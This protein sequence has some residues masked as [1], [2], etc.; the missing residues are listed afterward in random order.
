MTA[1]TAESPRWLNEQSVSDLTQIPVNTLRD[2]RK[3]GKV[4]L[5]FSK[6]GRLV[7]YSESAVVS[8]IDAHEVT[9]ERRAS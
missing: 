6:I 2:W 5:P 9:P 8:Y 3:P 7:R 4:V 1:A